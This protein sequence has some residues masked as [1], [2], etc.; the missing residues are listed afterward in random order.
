MPCLGPAEPHRDTRAPRV[1]RAP[2]A[3]MTPFMARSMTGFG[4][5]EAPLASGRLTVEV[6]SVNHRFLD[7][8]LNLPDELAGVAFTVEQ[9]LRSHLGRGRFDVVVRLTGPASAD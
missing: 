3:A 9:R 6:R 5:G 2:K 8:R 7:L 4:S 1:S